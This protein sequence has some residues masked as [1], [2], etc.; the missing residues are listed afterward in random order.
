MQKR[1]KINIKEVAPL[2]AVL[3][4]TMYF[5]ISGIIVSG[6]IQ[7]ICFLL[8][9]IITI[10]TQRNLCLSLI[11]I[12]LLLSLIPFF[13]SIKEWNIS[14]L[15]DLIAYFAFVVF[16]IFVKVESANIKKAIRFLYGMAF[17]HLFFVFINII[18]KDLYTSFLFSIVDS[19]L[20]QIYSK[21][22]AGNYYTGLAF[23]PG[24]TSGYLVNGIIILIFGNCLINNKY[25]FAKIVLLFIGMLFCAKKSHMVCLFTAVLVTWIISGKGE[26]IAKRIVGTILIIAIILVLGYIIMPH[27]TNIPMF[28]RTIIAINNFLSGK[29]FTSNRTNLANHAVQMF[30]DNKAF[31]AGWKAFNR[32]TLTRY[33]RTNYVNNVYL[34][35]VAETGIVGAVL[36]VFPMVFS[37]VKTLRMLIVNKNNNQNEKY[38]YTYIQLSFALQLFFLLYCFFEIPFYDYCFLFVYGLSIVISNCTDFTS[39]AQSNALV[40][41]N[42][43]EIIKWIR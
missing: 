19:S 13:Y 29:D 40:M 6:G 16:I 2:M 4:A 36:V 5:A 25:R 38:I 27:L 10:V 34:Q 30:N 22:V 39:V 7:I 42:D 26:K 31:G 18:F 35:L 33:G 1:I 20:I 28:N 41:H 43:K 8:F 14:T 11:D 32:F 9:I 24:D 23:I 15:R 21:A 17:F 37:F 12:L 3:I